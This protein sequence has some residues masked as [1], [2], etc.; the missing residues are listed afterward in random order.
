MKS[1]ISRIFLIL[2]AVFFFFFGIAF[3]I[4][5]WKGRFPH[6][7]VVDCVIEGNIVEEPQSNIPF[8]S[9]QTESL[10]DLLLTL[11]TAADDP[12]VVGVVVV[13]KPFEAGFGGFPTFAKIQELRSALQEVNKAG[14]WTAAY[15]YGS[16]DFGVIG[17]N[18]YYLASACKEIFMP[19]SGLLAFNGIYI[20]EV[21]AKKLL[22]KLGIQPEIQHIGK[23]KTASNFFTHSKATPAQKEMDTW[24][25]H[26]IF[27][28]LVADVSTDRGISETTL[29][30]IINKG[31]LM[32]KEAQEFKLITTSDYPDEFKPTLAREHG[33][34]TWVSWK[35]YLAKVVPHFFGRGKKIAI[36]YASGTIAGEENGYSPFFGKILGWKPLD[37]AFREIRDDPSIKAVVFRIDSPGGDVLT[38]DFIR[39]AAEETARKIPVV[40]SMSNVAGSGGYWI[41]AFQPSPMIIADPGTITA[42]IGVI[43]GKF[44]L[45]KFYNKLGINFDTTSQGRMALLWSLTDFNSDQGKI[46]RKE[47]LETY[48][49]FLN[50]VAKSRKMSVENVDR[51]GRGRVFTGEQAEKRHLVDNL[52][53]LLQAIALAKKEAGIKPEEPVQLVIYPKPKSL[54]DLLLENWKGESHIYLAPPWHNGQILLLMAP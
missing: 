28:Q 49:R 13:I 54:L 27:H 33:N 52:G 16:A 3:V 43:S 10:R 48:H 6:K 30:K 21:F 40:V 37:K 12:H 53:G 32:P 22:S 51:I 1:R 9:S 11:H 46:F 8:V 24:L 41:T 47:M 18:G 26:N 4:Y 38:S 36:V 39:H 23:Y 44:N 50:I 2:I 15:I 7:M 31:V 17:V 35:K 34:V 42:S 5:F 29:L 19:P 20:K 25:I 14:K 45:K